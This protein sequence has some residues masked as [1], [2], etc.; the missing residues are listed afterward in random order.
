MLAGMHIES[1]GIA[2]FLELRI[3]GSKAAKCINRN[4]QQEKHDIRIEIYFAWIARKKSKRNEEKHK[5]KKKKEK[6]D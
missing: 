4:R 5:K 2:S 6:G 1:V 3:E